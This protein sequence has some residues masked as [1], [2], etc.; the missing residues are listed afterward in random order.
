MCCVHLLGICMF[1]WCRGSGVRVFLKIIAVSCSYKGVP[2][3]HTHR[4]PRNTHSSQYLHCPLAWETT[5]QSHT[6]AKLWVWSSPNDQESALWHWASLARASLTC[7]LDD[8]TDGC[9]VWWRASSPA[10]PQ[11][12]LLLYQWPNYCSK[13]PYHPDQRMLWMYMYICIQS[14]YYTMHVPA[15]L[16]RCLMWSHTCTSSWWGCYSS[17][18]VTWPSSVYVCYT[19]HIC[20]IKS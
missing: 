16:D 14:P 9:V 20:I 12:V 4:H 5:A 18:G 11:Q 7:S 17:V 13:F 1:I 15:I 3:L 19:W 8:G 2:M 10:N 6:S